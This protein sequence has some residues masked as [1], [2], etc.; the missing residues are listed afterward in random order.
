MK[1][2]GGQLDLGGHTVRCRN[3]SKTIGILLI[4][5]KAQLTNGLVAGCQ[6]GVVATDRGQHRVIGVTSRE[7]GMAGFLAGAVA[8]FL[9][10]KGNVFINN[11]AEKT[12]GGFII[13]S[14]NEFFI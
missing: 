11:Q 2:P 14:P 6:V 5:E 13:N 7:H 12:D 9:A 10:G 3:R 4:G 8:K 1:G